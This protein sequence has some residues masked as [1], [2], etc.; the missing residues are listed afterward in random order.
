MEFRRKTGHP[1]VARGCYHQDT[2]N[3]YSET[4]AECL[5][6]ATK[7]GKTSQSASSGFRCKCN[8]RSQK[9][10]CKLLSTTK[11]SDKCLRKQTK[12]CCPGPKPKGDSC[13]MAMG[14]HRLLPMPLWEPKQL[15]SS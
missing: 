9:E 1:R 3:P 15:C 10:K 12:C 14:R 5:L 13:H 6:V 2:L 8:L 11:A 7:I 4:A